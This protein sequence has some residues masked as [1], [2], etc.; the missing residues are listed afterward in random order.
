M[1]R[2]FKSSAFW[3]AVVGSIFVVIAFKLTDG[4]PFITAMIGGFFGV[5]QVAKGAE[6]FVK[7]NRGVYYDEEEGRERYI[8]TIKED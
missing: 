4:D 7:A 3:N 8:E 1:K 6:G 5:K 2:L